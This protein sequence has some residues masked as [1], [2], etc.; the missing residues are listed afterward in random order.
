MPT[1]SRGD[2]RHISDVINVKMIIRL[3]EDGVKTGGSNYVDKIDKM[4]IK[5]RISDVRCCARY[6]IN[7]L[8]DVA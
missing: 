5:Q 1:M 2:T 3:K 4:Q 7:N 6:I 8:N